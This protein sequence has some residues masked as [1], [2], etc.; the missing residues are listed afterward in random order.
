MQNL[1]T[2]LKVFKIE[3]H[4]QSTIVAEAAPSPVRSPQTQTLDRSLSLVFTRQVGGTQSCQPLWA[5][6]RRSFQWHKGRPCSQGVIADS[7]H[8][9]T[10]PGQP[11]QLIAATRIM[12]LLAWVG[13][14]Q[15]EGLA[16]TA[17]VVEAQS[18]VRFKERMV[19]GRLNLGSQ[20][21]I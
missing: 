18:E 6:V 2:P 12:A 16:L 3:I 19:A 17:V 7:V 4:L 10:F 13:L 14:A 8:L 21:A 11:M 20:I 15:E 5:Q 9:P 1:I